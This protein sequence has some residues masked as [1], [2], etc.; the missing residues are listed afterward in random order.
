MRLCRKLS[1]KLKHPPV[2]YVVPPKTFAPYREHRREV[3]ILPDGYTPCIYIQGPHGEFTEPF[4]GIKYSERHQTD[5]DQWKTDWQN[6]IYFRA[7]YVTMDWIDDLYGWRGWGASWYYDIWKPGSARPLFRLDL[8][9][10]LEI[11][12]L[13]RP[14]RIRFDHLRRPQQMRTL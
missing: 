9:M 1:R 8:A 7:E 10:L 12:R 14:A 11:N 6:V 5:R 13:K 2:E 4:G 3:V